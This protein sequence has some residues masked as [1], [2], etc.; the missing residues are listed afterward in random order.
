MIKQACGVDWPIPQGQLLKVIPKGTTEVGLLDDQTIPI[1][2]FGDSFS[3]VNRNFDFFLHKYFAT[4]V[5][6]FGVSGGA[7]FDSMT[8]YFIN[9]QPGDDLAK[10]A[11]WQYLNTL[12]AAEPFRQLIPAVYG[13][14]TV[15][16]SLASS[17][18]KEIATETPVLNIPASANVTGHQYFAYFKAN[19]LG[20]VKFDVR[21][22]YQDGQ[23]ETI[24]VTRSPRVKNNGR[25]FVELNDA[26]KGAVTR[27]S[28]IAPTGTKGSVQ[29]K[30]CAEKS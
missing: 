1:V 15:A 23:V 19:D 3:A 4:D 18:V 28:L 7:F 9:L 16:A 5:L 29:G 21:V 2:L 8:S 22:E 26:I 24:P 20:L 11:I 13:E 30:V 12:P 14:C 27:I 10:I 6:N 25:Y 17:S